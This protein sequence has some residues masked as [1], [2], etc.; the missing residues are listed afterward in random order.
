[1][2]SYIM[3]IIVF[4]FS[5]LIITYAMPLTMFWGK[6]E[7]T[8]QSKILQLGYQILLRNLSSYDRNLRIRLDAFETPDET[9]Q[10]WPA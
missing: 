3:I 6:K 4:F 7:L 9:T 1:M 5:L 2:F 8:N 10:F